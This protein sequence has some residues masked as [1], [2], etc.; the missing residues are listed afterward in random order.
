VISIGGGALQLIA[1]VGRTFEEW[2]RMRRSLGVFVLLAGVLGCTRSGLPTNTVTLRSG[3]Q[4]RMRS[5]GPIRFTQAPPGLALSYETDLKLNDREALRQEITEIWQDFKAD[6]DRAKVQS[7]II[8]ANEK[9]TGF[10]LTHNRSYNFVF[11]RQ[12]DGSWPREASSSK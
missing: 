2:R 9:P 1:G 7:A 11:Q 6:A 10:I 12:S 8:M 3:K 4:I 5:I